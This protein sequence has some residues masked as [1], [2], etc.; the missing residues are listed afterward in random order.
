MKTLLPISFF[1][2]V[3]FV[4]CDVIQLEL[5]QNLIQKD[6]LIVKQTKKLAKLGKGVRLLERYDS[7]LLEGLSVKDYLTTNI[8]F[9]EP[10]QDFRVIVSTGGFTFPKYLK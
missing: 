8:S 6:A 2:F 9:A 7:K 1:L 3:A 5:Q 10:K 4:L